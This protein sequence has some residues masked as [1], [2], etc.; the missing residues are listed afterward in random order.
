MF[1]LLVFRALPLFLRPLVIILEGAL[2]DDGYIL[3]FLLPLT[4]LVVTLTSIPVHIDYYKSNFEQGYSS[5]IKVAYEASLTWIIIVGI[6][7]VFSIEYFISSIDGLNLLVL[8]SAVFL[9]IVEKF[10]DETSRMLE[11]KKKYYYW[12]LIQ[13]VRSGWMLFPLFLFILGFDYEKSFLIISFLLLIPIFI[14]FKAVT[15]LSLKTDCIGF[16]VIFKNI[17]FLFGSALMASYRQ[18]PR[19]LVAKMYPEYAHLYLSVAQIAQSSSILFNVKYQVPYR[20]LIARKTR[21]IQKKLQPT[22]FKILVPCLLI[23]FFYFFIHCFFDF[24]KIGDLIFVIIMLPILL[25]DAIIFSILA[26]H[27]GYLTWFAERNKILILYFVLSISS[28]F[29]CFIYYTF[30]GINITS[31]PAMVSFIGFFWFMI[32]KI[33][34]FR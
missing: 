17:I 2:V 8:F 29:F 16:S 5:T 28:I 6:A 3:I 32:I 7:I 11:F 22:I 33:I 20:K 12:F 31:I 9:F 14:I 13:C 24:K 4:M 10:S 34:F 1:K 25:S 21:I 30:I 26:A 27:L 23:V 19:I 15:G 18:V